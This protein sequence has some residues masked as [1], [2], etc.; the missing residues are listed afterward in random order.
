MNKKLFK[1][2]KNKQAQLK[3]LNIVMYIVIVTQ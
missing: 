1:M 2:K 3:E